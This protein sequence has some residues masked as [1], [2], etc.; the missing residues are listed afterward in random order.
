MFIYVCVC[1]YVYMCA[2]VSVCVFMCVRNVLFKT[3]KSRQEP[4]YLEN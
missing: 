3:K 1:V 4:K 2:C